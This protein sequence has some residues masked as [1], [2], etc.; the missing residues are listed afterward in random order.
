[1]KNL[2]KKDGISL[3]A[4]LVT[5]IVLIILTGAVVATFMEGGIIDKAKESVFKNDMRSYQEMLVVKSAVNEIDLQTGNG[6]VTRLNA[7]E[8]AKIQAI[9][10]EFKDEYREL[11]EI[12]EGELVLGTRVTKS[13]DDMTDDEINYRNWLLELGIGAEYTIGQE[14]SITDSEGVEHNFYVMKD[15]G[16]ELT[17]LAKDKINTTTYLQE[18]GNNVAFSSTNY[19]YDSRNS[20]FITYDL[21]DTSKIPE[22]VTTLALTAA[23]GY[24]EKLGGTGRLMTKAEAESWKDGGDLQAKLY[25]PGKYW[26]GTA[27]VS[28]DY[29]VWMV[30]GE[31][32]YL[33][34]YA[35]LNSL[36]VRPVI[37]ISDSKIN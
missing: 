18:S 16:S 17:L 26:L 37:T 11:V 9:I 30:N 6:T 22:G 14:V 28:Y 3:V 7:T 12:S 33:N 2:S 27:Y 31:D 13:E 15:S 4:L 34:D 5:I 36:G 21:N 20:R 23:I 32:G 10:P 35:Y 25:A 24:G 8:L 19:W 1:M 29:S